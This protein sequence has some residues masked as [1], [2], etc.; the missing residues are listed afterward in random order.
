MKLPCYF[1][2]KSFEKVE[3]FVKLI[4][5]IYRRWLEEKKTANFFIEPVKDITVLKDIG[6]KKDTKL[7]ED[8]HLSK[9]GV[10]YL[11]I[12]MSSLLNRRF[13]KLTS[14]FNKMTIGQFSEYF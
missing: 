5:F 1:K 10:R 7:I 4:S 3:M 13:S 14:D 8:L 12:L 9:N 2:L 11:S 6:I